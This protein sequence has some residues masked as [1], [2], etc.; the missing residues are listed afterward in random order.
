METMLI[1]SAQHQLDKNVFLTALVLDFNPNEAPDQF[2]TA[3][4]WARYA[5]LFT[6]DDD[7]DDVILGADTHKKPIEAEAEEA[8]EAMDM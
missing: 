3:V 6:F 1:S 7:S 2:D 5:E 4:N 8:G